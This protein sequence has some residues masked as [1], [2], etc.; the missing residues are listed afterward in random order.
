MS[1]SIHT[2]LVRTARAQQNYLRPYLQTLGLSHGQPKLLRC[3]A[4]LGPCTQRELAEHC[5]VDPAAIC[6]TLE[7]LERNGLIV[8][9]PSPADRRADQVSLTEPGRRVFLSWEHQCKDLE[10]Q[11]LRDFTPEE[12]AQLSGYLARA[13]RNV[14]GHPW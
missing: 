2:L 6:R 8:R 9:R 4:D 5:D 3:L 10:D 14:G 7:S 13:Y 1:L 12:R 11:M